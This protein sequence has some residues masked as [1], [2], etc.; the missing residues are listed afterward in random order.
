MVV[1]IPDSCKMLVVLLCVLVEP[2]F[3]H[4]LEAP[5]LSFY[6]GGWRRMRQRTSLAQADR[7]SRVSH[8]A[9]VFSAGAAARTRTCP[10]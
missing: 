5:H 3:Q 2:A 7:G 10:R 4:H 1:K 6:W 8:Y 9:C